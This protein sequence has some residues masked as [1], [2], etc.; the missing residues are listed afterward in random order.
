VSAVIDTDTP[1]RGRARWQQTIQVRNYEPAVAAAEI[2]FGFDP[3][4]P[5]SAIAGLR[6]AFIKC[7]TAVFDQFGLDFM[8]SDGVAHQVVDDVLGGR[9]EVVELAPSRP[10]DPPA[11]ASVPAEPPY[12][13]SS[14]RKPRKQMNDIEKAQANANTQWAKDRYD[15]APDEFY[16]N[17]GDKTNPNSPDLKHKSSGIGIWLD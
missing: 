6:D 12:D 8:V 4:D 10:S 7:K 16:D 3:D 15:F 5:E 9:S 17:R 2:D 14:L 13:P 1:Y 11:D